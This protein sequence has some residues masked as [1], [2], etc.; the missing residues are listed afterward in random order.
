MATRPYISYL[1]KDLI[2]LFD[3]HQNDEKILTALKKELV[4][5]DRPKAVK[6]LARVENRLAA[7][8]DGI[9]APEQLSLPI[10]VEATQQKKLPSLGPQATLPGVKLPEHS[11]EKV[12]PCLNSLMSQK[13]FSSQQEEKGCIS[14]TSPRPQL[15]RTKILDF[16]LKIFKGK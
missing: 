8:K 14:A 16:L 9:Q 2:E 13:I 3:K 12:E 15:N 5:R 1:T 10:Q 7:L 6:L 4:H 11:I